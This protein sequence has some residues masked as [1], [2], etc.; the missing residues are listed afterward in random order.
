MTDTEPFLKDDRRDSDSD[1]VHSTATHKPTRKWSWIGI[2]V[3]VNI[4]VLLLDL[5]ALLK[6][7]SQ[8]P[9]IT[10]GCSDLPPSPANPVVAYEYRELDESNVN[11]WAGKPRPELEDIWDDLMRGEVFRATREDLEMSRGGIDDSIELEHGGYLATLSVYHELHCLEWIKRSYARVESLDQLHE[12]EDHLD[13]CLQVI[14][15]AA[16]CHADVNIEPYR[17]EEGQSVPIPSPGKDHLCVKFRNVE[18][19]VHQ[20]LIDPGERTIG[21]DGR[22]RPGHNKY[23]FEM[24]N[25]TP[26]HVE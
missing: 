21:P 24:V 25:N 16:M 2:L 14:R 9:R 19:W 3:A 17:W 6:F 26:K 4:G 10:P 22:L 18:S 12:K 8:T 5:L 20:R 7:T 11:A 1:L 23:R 15:E 13:H